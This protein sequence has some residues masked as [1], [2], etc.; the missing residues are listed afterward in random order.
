S[1]LSCGWRHVAAPSSEA[2]SWLA[3]CCLK[4]RIVG[5]LVVIHPV[6]QFVA[7]GVVLFEPGCLTRH[8]V[9]V[10]RENLHCLVDRCGTRVDLSECLHMRELG[11]QRLLIDVRGYRIATLTGR[12]DR[13]RRA[14]W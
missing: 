3:P 9:Q 13:R 1:Y 2:L 6:C 8:G 7:V 12:R 14:C 11:L 5:P 4:E 10:Y